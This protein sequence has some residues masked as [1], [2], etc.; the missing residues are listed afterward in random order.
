MTEPAGH[1]KSL[2]LNRQQIP[3]DATTRIGQAKHARAIF[4]A[5]ADL[6]RYMHAATVKIVSCVLLVLLYAHGL[7]QTPEQAAQHPAPLDS[8]Q[9]LV[10]TFE[11]AARGDNFF[12]DRTSTNGVPLFTLTLE[13]NGTYFVFCA[14]VFVVPLI[15]G[16]GSIVPGNEIGTWRRGGDRYHPE[17]VLT[18]TNR[19]HMALLFPSHMKVD[20]GDLNRLT[21]I[22]PPPSDMSESSPRWVPLSSPYF[23]R[24][25]P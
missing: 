16:G 12:A 19:S 8:L 5:V 15:D 6:C 3:L 11:S 21:A 25:S 20:R 7:G 9:T 17:V 13:T 24:K 14:S 10:G 1:N 22:N 23:Y 4:S 18:A 2:L